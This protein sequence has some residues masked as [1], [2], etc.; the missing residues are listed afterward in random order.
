MSM[1]NATTITDLLALPEDGKLYE[2][3]DG[4]LREK[5]M[6]FEANSIATRIARRFQEQLEDSGKGFAATEALFRAPEWDEGH[7]R[8]PDVIYVSRSRVPNGTLPTGVL[9]VAPDVCVE[10][11]SP[12]DDAIE[13]DLKVEE[14]REAGV[15]LTIVVNPQTR[16]LMLFHQDGTPRRLYVTDELADEPALPGLRVAVAKFFP[17]T[18]GKAR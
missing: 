16:T 7:A 4:E 1:L 10:V 9:V 11:L 8:R 2:L 18:V 3:V 14:Y 13:V 12:N 5:E 15:Q 17:A 6:G